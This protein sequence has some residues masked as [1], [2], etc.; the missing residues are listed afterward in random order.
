[1]NV[2]AK[3]LWDH[4]RSSELLPTT[5]FDGDDPFQRLSSERQ[6]CPLWWL[7]W[8]LYGSVYH[9]RQPRDLVLWYHNR[10]K[11]TGP[12]YGCIGVCG[13]GH[14]QPH[15]P[16]LDDNGLPTHN[17][18]SVLAIFAVLCSSQIGWKDTSNS[19]DQCRY[20]PDYLTVSASKPSM[21]ERQSR[22]LDHGRGNALHDVEVVAKHKQLHDH[23]ALTLL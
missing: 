3:F 10:W 14:R 13:S 1:M 4:N 15:L 6:W 19:Y 9:V 17:V 21:H 12:W 16:C 5:F 18:W 23:L 20:A 2:H 22:A 7:E 11:E 8:E